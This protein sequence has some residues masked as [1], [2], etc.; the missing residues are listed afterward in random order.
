[1]DDFE[2]AKNSFHNLYTQLNNLAV[3]FEGA[4]SYHL[5][6][7]Y[8]S[9]EEEKKFTSTLF[10]A[11]PAD[12]SIKPMKVELLMEYVLLEWKIKLL[13][14]EKEREDDERGEIKAE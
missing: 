5:Q 6:G 2:K 3:H 1:T 14:Y 4:R 7:A 11:D 12:E 9:P 8:E 13:V 10:A